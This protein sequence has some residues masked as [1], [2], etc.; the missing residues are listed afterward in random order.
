MSESSRGREKE[1]TSSVWETALLS[2][3]R[4]RGGDV[5]LHELLGTFLAKA[6]KNLLVGEEERLVHF[7]R[8]DVY[9][10]S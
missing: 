1:R 4:R 3:G 8:M 5:D 9:S 2:P 7:L 6:M 10:S